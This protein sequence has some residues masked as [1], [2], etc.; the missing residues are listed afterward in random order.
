MRPWR[1]DVTLQPRASVSSRGMLK[2]A[3]ALHRLECMPLGE[4]TLDVA[5]FTYDSEPTLDEVFIQLDSVFFI[6][7]RQLVEVHAVSPVAERVLPIVFLH[8][9]HSDS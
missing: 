4:S 2:R 5:L 6:A 3:T 1:A 9:T 7:G 8:R